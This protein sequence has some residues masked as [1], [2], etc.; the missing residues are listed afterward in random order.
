[1][2]RYGTQAAD[3]I[4]GPLVDANTK[5]SIWKHDILDLD[6]IASPG[7]KVNNKQVKKKVSY[8]FAIQLI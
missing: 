1:M 8:T 2:K 5:K 6:G 7:L 3:R 4:L